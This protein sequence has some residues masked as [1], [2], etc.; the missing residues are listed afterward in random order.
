MLSDV[1]IFFTFSGEGRPEGEK[2]RLENHQA[3]FGSRQHLGG[4]ARV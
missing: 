3:A 2:K 1:N 4:D